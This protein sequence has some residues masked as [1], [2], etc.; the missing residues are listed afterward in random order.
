[1][2]FIRQVF[3]VMAE[4]PQH[5]FQVLTKRAERAARLAPRLRWPENVW[6]GVP[7]E[8][9]EYVWR[10]DYLREIH[11]ATRSISAEPLLAPRFD[12]LAQ[13]C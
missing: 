5:T 8:S 2:A 12:R 3:G 9:P 6:M 7:V 1:M 13:S 10:V 4:C 11:A